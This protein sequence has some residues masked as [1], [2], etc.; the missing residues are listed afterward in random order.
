MR[1]AFL[2]GALIAYVPFAAQAAGYPE[3]PIRI[4]TPFPAGSVTDLV[5]RPLAAKLTDA[6]GINVIVDNRPGAGGNV[7]GDIVAKSAPD[8]YTLMIGST[9]PNAVNVSLMKTMPYDTLRAFA[10]ISLVATTYLMLVVHP[11]TPAKSVG[12]LIALAKARPGQLTYGSSGNGAT[13]H[14]AGELFS[15]MA[16]VRMI[17]V[18]Y[19]GGSPAY[20]ID[21]IS[22]RIDLAF[23][24]ILPSIPHIKSGKLRLLAVSGTKRGSEFP[25]VPTISESGVPGYDMRSW[26]G[27]LASAGTPQPTIAKLNTELGRALAQPDV[28]SQ[29]ASGGLVATSS[30]PAAFDQFIRAEHEKWAKLIKS[31]G[32]EAH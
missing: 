21:L 19:K 23:A 30:T 4:V 25:D 24:S 28:R 12:D 31:A 14:L 5:A 10:P 8:G 6:W 26:Y 15:S 1:L 9:G 22:G 3:R 18:P 11:G 7:A 32:I 2:A 20:T 16:G 13:P 27:V 29:Y 17:H